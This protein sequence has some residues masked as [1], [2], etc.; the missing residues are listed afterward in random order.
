MSV[1]ETKEIDFLLL[2]WCE[3]MSTV[4]IKLLQDFTRQEELTFH[5][6]LLE[7]PFATAICG[8]LKK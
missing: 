7:N 6:N 8:L 1:S 3:S 2:L 4:F 5:N